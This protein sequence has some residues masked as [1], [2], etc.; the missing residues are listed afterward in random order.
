MNR[1]NLTDTHLTIQ[2]PGFQGDEL[3]R[4]METRYDKAPVPYTPPAAEVQPYNTAKAVGDLVKPVVILSALAGGVYMVGVC[5]IAVGAAII[6]TVSA[7]AVPI[8]GAAAAV[9]TLVLCFASRKEPEGKEA[10][11]NASSGHVV[12]VTVNIA[13]ESINVTKQ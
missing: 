13:G 11:K 4:Y 6:T 5:A 8:G 7:Y 1:E 9:V 10:A 2:G 12:N 3:E